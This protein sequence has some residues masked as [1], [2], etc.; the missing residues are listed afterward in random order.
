MS[1]LDIV[2]IVILIIPTFMGF[3]A[4]IIK[5]L[6]SIAGIIVGII[7]AGQFS[8]SLAGL[9]TFIAD[10]G[11]AKVAAFVIILVVVMVIAA[12]LAAVIKWALSAVLLGWVNRLGG[13][14]LGFIVGALFCGAGLALLGLLLGLGPGARRLDHLHLHLRQPEHGVLLGVPA[15]V[16][17]EALDALGVPGFD[18]LEVLRIDLLSR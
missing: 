13:A 11:W 5:M 14:V 9:L 6:F 4:G 2:I 16:L 15:L 7:L 18:F 8:D 3:K 12:V 10:P 1:W 17:R